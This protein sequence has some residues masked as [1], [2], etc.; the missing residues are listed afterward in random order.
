ML[1][2]ARPFALLGLNPIICGL[3]VSSLLGVIMSLCPAPP[4]EERI[5]RLFDSEA[6][7]AMPTTA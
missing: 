4:D 6:P 3:A 1:V 7:E 5:S 2:K